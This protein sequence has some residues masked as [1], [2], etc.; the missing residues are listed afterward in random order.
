MPDVI[1]IGGGIYG[2]ALGYYLRGEGR[3]VTVLERHGVGH[4]G[5]GRNTGGVRQQG[6]VRAET[7]L[8]MEAIAMWP[9]LDAEL[10]AA[11]EYTRRGNLLIGGTDEQIARIE[12]RLVRQRGFDLDSR[13]IDGAELRR[14]CPIVGPHAKAAL[15]CPTDGHANPLLSTLAYA[16]AARRRGAEILEGVPAQGLERTAAGW[17]VRTPR[18]SLEAEAVINVAGPGAVEVCN[19]AGFSLPI[20]NARVQTMV[21]ERLPPIFDQFVQDWDTKTFTRQTRTGNIVYGDLTEDYVLSGHQVFASDCVRATRA[22]IEAFPSFAEL[23]VIRAW[24]GVLDV[25]L[26]Q[27]P[28]IG[29]V[30]GRPGLFVAAGSSGHGFGI[31]PAAA[32]L[33]ASWVARGTR[34]SLLAPFA[35]ERFS[36]TGGVDNIDDGGS[37]A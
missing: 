14:L 21:T 34:P 26:D 25:S 30:P 23:T 12:S 37:P 17:R 1:V 4:E 24:G 5:S 31:A 20:L 16:G 22:A 32:K 15:Y 9:H 27:M 6:R 35:L 28:I 13:V 19:W 11:T 7:P 36:A 2:C 8:A 10:G 18:G 29:E 33:L 3:S